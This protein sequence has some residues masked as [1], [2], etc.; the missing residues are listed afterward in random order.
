MT[1]SGSSPWR[2]L[3]L[4]RALRRACTVISFRQASPYCVA[5]IPWIIAGCHSEPAQQPGQGGQSYEAALQMI[6]HVDELAGI[7]AADP[8]ASEMNRTDWLREKLENPDAIEF[9]TLWRV[10][11]P[12]QRSSKL[13][14][15]AADAGISDCPLA[16]VE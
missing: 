14:K 4:V 12:E 5:C 6:C 3:R 9:F 11:E 2:E 13:E 1:Q 16:H 8:I 15:A 7:D 10:A